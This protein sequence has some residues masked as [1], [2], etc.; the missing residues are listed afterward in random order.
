MPAPSETQ[1][2]VQA[3]LDKLR[4]QA[5]VTQDELTQLQHSLDILEVVAEGSH[6]HHH[7]DA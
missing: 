7:H 1:R 4:K 5:R 6:H 2:Q 3:I